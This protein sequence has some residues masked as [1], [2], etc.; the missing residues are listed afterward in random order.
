MNL[1][2]EFEKMLE[3]DDEKGKTMFGNYKSQS[4]HEMD[5]IIQK[6]QKDGLF[7]CEAAQIILQNNKYEM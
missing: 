3:R 4:L 1:L 6:Y 2:G 7:L 5:K